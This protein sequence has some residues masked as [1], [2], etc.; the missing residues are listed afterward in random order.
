MPC[1]ARSMRQTRLAMDRDRG[2]ESDYLLSLSDFA[3]PLR[4]RLRT[5]DCM[6][7]WVGLKN[8]CWRR[9]QD[10]IYYRLPLSTATCVHSLVGLERL[11]GSMISF[12]WV[13]V[14]VDR[15]FFCASGLKITRRFKR[16]FQSTDDW[17]T[18]QCQR[19]PTSALDFLLSHL[20]AC[21]LL[22]Y[23]RAH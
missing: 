15:W 12:P 4:L 6:G 18:W 5:A 17:L 23:Y 3:R 11:G 20:L 9:T 19:R 7:C 14:V 21:S 16:T 10:K 8:Y 22:I 13:G 1:S 2:Q